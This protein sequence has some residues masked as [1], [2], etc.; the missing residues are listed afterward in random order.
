VQERI[1]KLKDKALATDE[2]TGWIELERIKA[3]AWPK[4]KDQPASIRQAG[5]LSRMLAEMTISVEPEDLLAGSIN[6]A[7]TNSYDL[8]R[9]GA[10][11][12]LGKVAPPDVL[13]FWK[14]DPY[15]QQLSKL[16]TPL[17]QD[18]QNETVCIG[19]R[20]T[21]HMVPD[22]PR[23]LQI[24]L[25]G[26]I[27]QA[28]LSL[29]KLPSDQSEAKGKVFYQ[30][31]VIAAEA[32][33]AVARRY[34]D[35]ALNLAS[36]TSDPERKK[37]LEQLAA[38][39]EQVPLKPARTFAEALQSIWF[40]YMIMTIEQTPNPYAFSI[41]RLDQVLYPYY[42]RDLAAGKITE[43]EALEFL[44]AFWLKL[45]VGKSC[46]AV[47]Q[48]ILLGGL[49]PE[50]KDATNPVS[51]LALRATEELKTPQPSVAVRVH[52]NSP[53][54]FLHQAARVLRMGLGIPA[55]HNDD[56]VVPLKCSEGIPLADARD[57]AIAGCQEPIV[58]GK[59]NARTTGGKFNLAKCLELAL[60]DGV[61]TLS[62]KQLGPKTGLEF[63][64]F[65][66][67]RKAYHA[68]EEF[69]V[70]QMVQMHNRA[71]VLIARERPLPFLSGLIAGCL[72]KGRDV[73][74]DGALYNFTGVLVHGLANVADSLAA[75]KRLVFDEKLIDMSTLL[76]VLRNNFVDNE[77]LRQLL[78]NRAP[79]YG[80]DVDEVDLLAGEE[81][82]FMAAEVAK[83]KNVW[84]GKF[85]AGFNTPSTHVHY[86]YNTGATPDGRKAK[87]T[88]AYGTG[89]ME[90]RPSR[91]PTAVINSVT[92]FSHAPAVNGTDLN[93][94]FT[95]NLLAGPAGLATLVAAVRTL[96]DRGA[97]HIQIN[98][99][100]VETLRAAQAHPEAY[101]DLIVRVHGFSTFFTSLTRDIQEDIIARTASTI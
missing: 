69:F 99:V 45:V 85:N 44:E 10:E 5:L 77:P 8:Y 40:I 61:S 26:V 67:V 68:Q 48:N 17:E 3:R 14:A 54:D 53:Q 52:Q 15:E 29:S 92:K 37:D 81:L 79:K 38:R 91:G 97:H 78:L 62:G 49:T 70:D 87:E 33:I 20:V 34:R 25:E 22:F 59:E 71:E 73:R 89:P 96:F 55:F 86:G 51:F 100:D 57:Y 41:G 39:C 43:D 6:N 9:G 90:G 35:E 56:S 7:F 94:S 31:V 98:V 66:S 27:A 58:G 95:P 75:V 72:E 23:I 1:E 83:Y 18:I 24:G 88:L 80:N 84:G 74:T 46:W 36:K 76:I 13:A 11:R 82:A 47:S 42:A 63:Q 21:G 2:L 30:A 4:L 101:R 65:S 16:L 50:G 28:R 32:A 64:D 19:K 12:S 60:N 93:L